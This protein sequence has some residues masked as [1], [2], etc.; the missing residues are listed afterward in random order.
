[1]GH[2]D[3]LTPLGAAVVGILKQP[4]AITAAAALVVVH[5]NDSVIVVAVAF[6]MFTV[7]ST[8]TVGLMYLYYARHP[9]EAQARLTMLRDRVVE[10]GPVVGA[11]MGLLVGGFLIT[12]ALLELT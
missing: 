8:A 1:M 7:A 9:G 2:M 11:V 3:S 4:W 10:A 6:A 12:T 5:R